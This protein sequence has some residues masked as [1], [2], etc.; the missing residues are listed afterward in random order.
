[1]VFSQKHYE[2]DYLVTYQSIFLDSTKN[3]S[4]Q[5]LTNSKKNNYFAVIT[6]KSDS[7]NI[8]HFH[9]RHGLHFNVFF[10]KEDLINAE[11]INIKCEFVVVGKFM[12][13]AKSKINYYDYYDLGNSKTESEYYAN[14]KLQS[15]NPKRAKRKKLGKY[16]YILSD[17]LSFHL[18]LTIT[19]LEYEL[20]YS[21]PKIP[22]GLFKERIYT[23]YLDEI[24]HR[25]VLKKIEKITKK[26]II[27]SEC[28]PSN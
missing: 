6:E 11:I 13:D 22:K 10:K 24:Q 5:F 21:N 23:N 15:T 8:L 7:E 20:W 17:S 12:R 1:M 28:S 3:R 14:Y 16:Y 9:D 2:F 26:I 25:Y 19:H 18:P 4:K 27:P